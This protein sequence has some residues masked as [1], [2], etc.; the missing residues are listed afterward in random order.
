MADVQ[1]D[2]HSSQWN[3]RFFFDQNGVPTIVLLPPIEDDGQ[4]A[5]QR[6]EISRTW[7]ERTRH[8]RNAAVAYP[9]WDVKDLT[10][11]QRDMG[12]IA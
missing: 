3:K 8:R 10:V 9:G 1:G 5:A 2:F 11:T 12:H 4:T 7:N 6:E